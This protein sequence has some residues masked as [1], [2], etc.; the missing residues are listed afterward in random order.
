MRIVLLVGTLLTLLGCGSSLPE[1][2]FIVV[3]ADVRTARP[4]LA[5][6]EGFAVKEGRFL[7]VG[8]EREVRR[9]GGPGTRVIDLSGST[10]LPAR[11]WN[12]AGTKRVCRCG[13]PRRP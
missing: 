1:A 12:D 2:D 5:R 10:V 9:H 3:G 4:E 11:S 8:A 7:A 13:Q 6:A